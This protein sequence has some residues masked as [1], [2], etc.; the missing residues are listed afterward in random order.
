[1]GVI[2]GVAIGL[3]HTFLRPFTA[4]L[5]IQS[6][7]TFFAAYA[8]TAFVMRLA[9][10]RLPMRIGIPAMVLLGMTALC[11]SMLLY[12]TVHTTWQL[13]LPGVAAGLG[14]AFLFPSIVTGGAVTFPTR[15]RGIG[16]ALILAMFDIGNLIGMPLA[17]SIV[18]Y[19]GAAGWPA[20]PTMFVTMTIIVAVSSVYYALRPRRST[21]RRS[22]EDRRMSDRIVEPVEPA[23][24]T[25]TLA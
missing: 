15:Y 22:S 16:T 18:E 13:V 3:P 7:G 21:I 24:L 10:C 19:A 20:Y 23:E 6:I 1:M 9:T 14:H 12:M 25:G 11:A 4:H 8:A 5:H 2:M 17:G